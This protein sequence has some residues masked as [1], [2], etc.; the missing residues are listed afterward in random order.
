MALKKLARD[1]QDDLQPQPL[2]LEIAPTPSL[3]SWFRE[4]DSIAPSVPF[5]SINTNQD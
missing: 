2:K 3:L 4:F 5:L 1:D